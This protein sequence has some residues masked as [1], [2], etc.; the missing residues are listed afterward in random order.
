M[1]DSALRKPPKI[2]LHLR[3]R[4]ILFEGR[5]AIEVGKW[6]VRFLI[7]SIAIGLI[8]SSICLLAAVGYVRG[9]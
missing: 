4:K 6:P 2:E 9:F 1:E 7:Y 8:T 3:S 5:E